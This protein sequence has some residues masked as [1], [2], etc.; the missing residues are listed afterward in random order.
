MPGHNP[1]ESGSTVQFTI[2]SL[3]KTVGSEHGQQKQLFS[4]GVLDVV[5]PGGCFCRG[6]GD[7][8]SLVMPTIYALR[9]VMK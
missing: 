7:S 8:L 1:C 9:S 5:G 4:A 6:H 3:S 2:D